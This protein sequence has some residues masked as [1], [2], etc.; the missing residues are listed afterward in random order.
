MKI[1]VLGWGS[2]I[3]D[4][5]NLSFNTETDW[6]SNGPVMPIEF[7]RISN[8]GRLTLVITPNGTNV[9]TL[10]AI[11]NFN[12]IE[13]AIINLS[14]REGSPKSRIGYYIKSENEFFPANFGF[15]NNILDWINLTDIDAVIWTNLAENWSETTTNRI[16]Y[17]DNLDYDKKN[18][19]KVY[20]VNA[21]EQIKTDLR[22]QI[23]Q[24][25]NWH[26]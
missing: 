4:P 10:Y 22:T 26:K 17:L 3:W 8:N 1:A 16:E 15:R 5:Q 6:Q 11:S 19:A 18:I 25:F 7:A 9:T 21:P 2:L 14:E 13:H 20:I 24:R 23:E 12:N